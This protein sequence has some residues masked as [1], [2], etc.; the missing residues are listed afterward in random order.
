MLTDLNRRIEDV[1]TKDKYGLARSL[2]VLRDIR[3]DMETRYNFNC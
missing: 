3:D 1:A 2:P